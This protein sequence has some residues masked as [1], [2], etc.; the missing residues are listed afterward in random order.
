M[1]TKCLV[2]II[3]VIMIDW[4]GKKFT[5]LVNDNDITY[6]YVYTWFQSQIS[7]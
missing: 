6:Y 2:R 5:S 3:K 4:S 1:T 7:K